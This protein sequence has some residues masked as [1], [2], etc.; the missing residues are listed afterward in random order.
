MTLTEL[1]R[2]RTRRDLPSQLL[3]AT[4]LSPPFNADDF[5]RV[6]VD[7]QPGYVRECPWEPSLDPPVPGEPVL[8]GESDEG[9][10]WVLSRWNGN[11][12][13]VGGGGG[14]GAT[15]LNGAGPPAAALG[16]DGDFYIDTT[17]DAIYGPKTAG[18]WGASTP[19]IGPQG[20]AG[21]AGA[22]GAQGNPGPAGAQ[23]PQGLQG[24]PGAAGPAGAQGPA[25]PVGPVGPEGPLG[26]QGVQGPSGADGAPGA[27]G[28]VGPEG[29]QGDEGLPGGAT[30]SQAIGNGAATTFVITHNLGTR[31]VDVLVR[32][33]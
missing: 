20:P 22:Q 16:A 1:T 25:G 6:V 28:P 13:S 32:D 4:V 19:L 7:S 9:N 31:D 30:F 14:T 18:A 11:P 10:L 27:Q 26:P 17:A 2:Q 29:P 33:T 15:I 3:E 8:V 21:A 23:G 5:V 24:D 12:F